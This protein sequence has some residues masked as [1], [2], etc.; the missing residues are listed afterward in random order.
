MYVRSAYL[1]AYDLGAYTYYP[2][3]PLLYAAA[4]PLQP[5]AR[6]PAAEAACCS[7]PTLVS[8]RDHRSR[9]SMLLGPSS[10]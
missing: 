4:F 8:K 1:H 10:I 5:K 6:E 3:K 7:Y 2:F 9:N